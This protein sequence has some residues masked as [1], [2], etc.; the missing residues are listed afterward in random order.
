L[1]GVHHASPDYE[2]ICVAELAAADCATSSDARLAHL[3][4]ALRNALL[5]S[6]SRR[7]AAPVDLMQWRSRRLHDE[8][9][10]A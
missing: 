10:Q 5:A 6:K 8:G 1:A 2:A 7:S 9:R 3:D 4:L